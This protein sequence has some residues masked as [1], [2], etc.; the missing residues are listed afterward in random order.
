MRILI[1]EDDR[2]AASYIR[3]GL[4][5]SGHVAD[6]AGDGEEGLEMARAA[7]YDVLRDDGILYAKRLEQDGVPVTW[8][9]RVKL[10]AAESPD[11][12]DNFLSH[13]KIIGLRG[14]QRSRT[15]DRKTN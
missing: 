9:R 13:E 6:H 4:R 12:M 5:E 1:V 3:K 10:T 14:N 11:G 15:R 2:E 8:E 7:E